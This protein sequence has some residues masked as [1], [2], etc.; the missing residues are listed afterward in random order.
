MCDNQ[1]T[2][3]SSLLESITKRSIFP[4]GNVMTTR[5]PV[6]LVMEHLAADTPIHIERVSHLLS[7]SMV[8]TQE[9]PALPRAADRTHKMV[10]S[11]GLHLHRLQ[12]DRRSVAPGLPAVHP[13][14]HCQH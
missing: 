2:G 3:K 14:T 6:C 4:R 11:R 9:L 1:S 7:C 10:Q 5:A 8:A 13:G 12:Q